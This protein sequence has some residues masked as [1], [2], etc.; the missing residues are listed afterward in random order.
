MKVMA[1]FGAA[2]LLVGVYLIFAGFFMKRKNE[3]GTIILAE[4]EVKKCTD[5]KGFIA[6]MY[7]REIL[8]GGAIILLGLAEIANDLFEDVGSIPYIGVIAGIVALLWFFY[9]LKKARE[10]FLQ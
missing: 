10:L 2:M 1:I 9:S 6:F 4:E 3:I 5:K 8:V 7:W